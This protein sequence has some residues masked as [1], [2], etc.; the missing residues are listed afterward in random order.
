MKCF[1]SEWLTCEISYACGCVAECSG[2]PLFTERREPLFPFLSTQNTVEQ[3]SG[4]LHCLLFELYCITL[5][6]CPWTKSVGCE[7]SRKV[8]STHEVPACSTGFAALKIQARHETCVSPPLSSWATRSIDTK[9]GIHITSFEAIPVSYLLL[10]FAPSVHF[11][12]CTT[13]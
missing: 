5:L 10:A 8:F 11:F 7:V 13:R 1:I 4:C 9:F 3:P 6:F 12:A 2:T